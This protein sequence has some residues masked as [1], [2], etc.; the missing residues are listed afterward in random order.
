MVGTLVPGLFRSQDDK[1]VQF[2]RAQSVFF[3]AEFAGHF[4]TALL[5]PHIPQLITPQREQ[6]ALDLFLPAAAPEEDLMRFK[7]R[8]WYITENRPNYRDRPSSI[9][10]FGQWR[11]TGDPRH[12]LI[13]FA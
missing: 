4:S 7:D 8:I 13:Y 3:A 12:D 6:G 5:Q 11:Q 2:S 9:E 10:Q 1:V